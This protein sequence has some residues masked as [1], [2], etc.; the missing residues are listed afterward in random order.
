MTAPLLLD[1]IDA[2][3]LL[4]MPAARVKRLAKRGEIPSVRL[5]DGEVRFRR[6]DLE[7]W[8]EEHCSQ[9]QASDSDLIDLAADVAADLLMAV[10]R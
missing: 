10:P 3:K 6:A 7:R 4:V 9:T 5:P 1:H 8:V 2:G